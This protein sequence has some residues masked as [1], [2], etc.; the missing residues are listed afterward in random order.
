MLVK[1]FEEMDKEKLE[2]AI[3]EFFRINSVRICHVT[4]SQSE[5]QDGMGPVKIISIFFEDYE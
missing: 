2:V 1:I 4:Q 3:N 5:I